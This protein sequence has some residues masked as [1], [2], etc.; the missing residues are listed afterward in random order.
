VTEAR[1]ALGRVGEELACRAL[2]AHG[3][4]ILARRYRARLGELDI[5]A[6][7]GATL[8]FVEVKAR[9]DRRFGDPPAAVTWRKQQRLAVM[10]AE[11][12]NAHG[13]GHE[14]CR[15]DV[16]GVVVGEGEPEVEVIRDAF[17]PGWN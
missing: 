16:V 17:R 3:Y 2:E 4:T 10:A 13:L 9:Q 11:Y 12:L 1:Q 7:D 6:R 8:V 5:V 14:R 15:F